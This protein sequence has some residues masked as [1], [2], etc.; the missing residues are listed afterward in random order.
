MM[1]SAEKLR[2]VFVVGFL[3]TIA[4]ALTSYIDSSFLSTQVNIRT[5]GILFALGSCVSIIFLSWLPDIMNRIGVRGVFH[6]TGFAYL[7]SVLGMLNITHPIIFG[8]CFLFYIASGYGIYF[9]IDML[10]ESMSEKKTTGITR[11]VYLAIYNLAYLI[12]PLLA[13]MLLKNNSFKLVYLVAGIFVIIMFLVFIKDLENIAVKPA[14]RRISFRKI[15]ERLLRSTHLFNVYIV[16]LL[17]SF[18]FSWMAIYT[19]IYLHTFLGFDWSAIGMMFAIMHIPYITLEVPIGR[20]VDKYGCEGE[21]V[22]IGLI[23]IAAATVGLG[24]FADGH[25]W[26]WVIGLT[27]TRVGASFVQVASESYFFKRVDAQ[28]SYMI[29]LYRNASPL[30]YILGPIAG[31]IVLSF[32]N[33]SNLFIV[34]GA[35]MLSVTIFSMRLNHSR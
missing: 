10:I 28:D 5:I 2:S 17:L 8:I 24:L 34:L 31:T 26:S 15:V 3:L 33:Y 23:V 16:S 35:I 7:V 20:L 4:L 27:L 25:F 22:T 30:A 1:K 18:F 11:G 13:G 14:R 19:P 29:A 21:L 9:T 6:L 32:T 12:G